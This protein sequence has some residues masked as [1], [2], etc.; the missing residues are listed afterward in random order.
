[1]PLLQSGPFSLESRSLL[2]L[3]VIGRLKDGVTI[4]QA[5]AQLQ[6]FWPE[7]LLATASTETPGL[8]RQTFLSMGLEVSRQRNRRTALLERASD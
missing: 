6:C 4:E 7:V 5:Q 2:W 1:M 3:H 8:R